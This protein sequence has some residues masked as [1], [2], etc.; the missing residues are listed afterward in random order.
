[1]ETKQQQL[2]ELI[3]H[4]LLG[5][6]ADSEKAVF[7]SQ[8][9]S[10]PQ[11]KA[12]VDLHQQI[13][14]AIKAKNIKKLLQQ[15]EFQIHRT[16]IRKRVFYSALYTL[17]AAACL[18]VGFFHF[19]GV[20]RYR[21][22]GNQAYAALVIS[23]SRG[24]SDSVDYAPPIISASRG[25][26]NADSFLLAAYG[27]T[28]A[29]AYDLAHENIDKAIKMWQEEPFNLATEEGLYDYQLAQTGIDKAQWLKAVTYMK[30]GKRSKAKALL[31]KIASGNGIY[32]SEA[33]KILETNVWKR[34]C[35]D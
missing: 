10:D 14:Y 4:Y 16:Q 23:A 26:G 34:D 20:S 30:Q 21:S 3:D 27:H 22:F 5:Q 9:A 29:G 19:E 35:G 31:Q 11:L 12:D 17:A 24:D 32:K 33:Q 15:Q 2:D 18:V 6:M 8:V 13:I 25:G 28:G 1:M 7:E